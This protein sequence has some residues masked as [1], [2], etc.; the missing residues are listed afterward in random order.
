MIS[1]L[2]VTIE[3]RIPTAAALELDRDD[4]ERRVPMGASSRFVDLD[5]VDLTPVNNSHE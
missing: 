1:D 3:T 2:L 4:V 5:T